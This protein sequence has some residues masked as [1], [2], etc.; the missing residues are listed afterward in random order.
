[1][2]WIKKATIIVSIIFLSG[3]FIYAA[4]NETKNKIIHEGTSQFFPESIDFAGEKTPLQISDVRERLDR[5]L[6][7]NANLD[8]S[9]LLII[10]RA[11]HIS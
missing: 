11:N 5:E 1:M 6:L 7:V 8:A 2:N 9:T 4:S 3:L 10:K